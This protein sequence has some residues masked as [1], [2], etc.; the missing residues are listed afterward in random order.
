VVAVAR[1]LRIFDPDTIYHITSHGIVSLP[2][3][4]DD[5]D[6]WRFIGMLDEV[7]RKFKWRCLA[8]C[9]M[10]TH[11]HLLVRPGD[12]PSRAMHRLN[13]R[14]ALEFN[15]RHGRRG[16]VFESRYRPRAVETDS[17]LLEVIR[18]IAL[19]PVRA[20]L[21]RT[22][23]GWRWSSYAQ[24]IGVD[25]GWSFVA[26]REVLSLFSSRRADATEVTRRFVDEGP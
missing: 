17:H 19:N 23:E 21:A 16:H 11:Y 20:G 6:R 9:L 1:P 3:F 25:R 12:D 5:R 26:S 4:V 7:T 2:I 18:Y 13:G 8:F 10:T 24:L 15:R 14:Y 22:P